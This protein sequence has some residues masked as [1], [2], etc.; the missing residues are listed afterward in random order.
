[1]S[2]RGCVYLV[3]A[4]PGDPGLLTVRG[5]DL[6][7]RADVLVHDRLIPDEALHY[8]PEDAE[9]INAGKRPG[10]HRLTQEEI[11]EVLVDRASEGN[12]VVRLKGGDPFIFG[13]GGEEA[14][15]LARAGMDF[16][17]VPGVTAGGA[18]P[19]CAGIPVTHRDWAGAV[20]FVTGHRADR[21]GGHAINWD[22][23]AAWQGTLVFYMGVSNLPKIAA[24]LTDGGMDDSTP[25][26]V[27]AEGCTPH[28]RVARGTL[29][30]IAEQADEA[31]I[32]PPAVL[33]VGRVASL[34]DE[35][36]WM[37]KRPLF[38]QGVVVT[39]PEG[40]A[41][42][43]LDRLRE[44]GADPIHV[45]T[46]K[47][48]PAEDPGP[49]KRE[50]RQ[51]DRWDWVLFTSRNGVDYFFS[52][53]R[54]AGLDARALA[55]CSIGAIGPT[56]ATRLESCGLTADMVPDNYTT[57]GMVEKLRETGQLADASVLCPRSDIAPPDL[58]TGLAEG[59]A[60]VEE[61]DAYSVTVDNRNAEHADELMQQGGVQWLTFTSSSTVRNFFSAVDPEPARSGRVRIASIGPRTSATLRKMDLE[62]D[63]A[64]E[65]A[66]MKHV[67]DAIVRAVSAE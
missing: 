60:I 11:N 29:A 31:G 30:D 33:V 7:S 40:Q 3:G 63:V 17:V 21:E 14:Q 35:L 2:E 1:M 22:A 66:T 19:A 6:L 43:A 52:A 26:A 16:E 10:R 62:P 55:S 37:E 13:R 41:Q 67:I 34:R 54:E 50:I 61:V 45:P 51:L 36:K 28:Q 64:A 38:G 15:Q 4:G 8:V 48:G 12:L 32:E 46:I 44:L 58:V 18:A 5:R 49:M 42:E 20:C 25:A 23:L 9:V 53:L 59:G 24:R 57:E 39:R 27:V 65:E 47:I 56:T